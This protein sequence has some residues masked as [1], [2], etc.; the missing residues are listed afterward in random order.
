MSDFEEKAYLSGYDDS[1]EYLNHLLDNQDISYNNDENDDEEFDDSDND[2]LFVVSEKNIQEMA[3]NI[4]NSLYWKYD[5]LKPLEY[6]CRYTYQNEVLFI[7]AAQNQLIDKLGWLDIEGRDLFDYFTI[8]IDYDSYY[9][10]A[11]IQGI[12]LDK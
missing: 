10:L 3:E 8:F 7:E 12:I 4:L 9:Y 6:V 2:I 1:E 5:H 11:E